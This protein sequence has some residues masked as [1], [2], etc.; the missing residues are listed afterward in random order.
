LHSQA[1]ARQAAGRLL[2]DTESLVTDAKVLTSLA[3]GLSQPVVRVV[4]AA[5]LV[6][7][8]LELAY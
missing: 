4:A 8:G 7:R 2:R 3:E 6:R 1:Q 5:C